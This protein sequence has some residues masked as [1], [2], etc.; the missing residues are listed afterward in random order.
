MKT[1]KNIL[2]ILLG[3]IVVAITLIVFI[4]LRN[5][6]GIGSGAT[7]TSQKKQTVAD[8]NVTIIT[9]AV[10]E[11]CVIN[12]NYLKL[13]N[14]EL[15]KDGHKYQLELKYFPYE[16]Y[17]QDVETE[18]KNGTVDVAFL[19]IGDDSNNIYSL[20]NSGSILNLDEILT[21]EKGKIVYDAFPNALWESVKC[22]KHIYSIPQTLAQETRVYAAFNTDYI[23]DEVIKNWDGSIDGIYKIIKDV[24]WDDDDAPRFQYLLSDFE[25]EQM[26][27]CEIK[28]GLLYDYETKQIIKPLE[29]EKLINYIKTLEQMKSDGFMNKSVSYAVDTTSDY[30]PKNVESG[31]F[32]I[33]LGVGEP[34]ALFES[35]N[36]SVKKL[37]PVLSS[38]ING[39]IGIS[40]KTDNIDEVIDFLGLLYG[41]SKYA[42]ILLYGRQD[43]DYKL[44]DG[45]AVNMDG[46]DIKSYFLTNLSLNLFINVHP[47][48]GEIFPENRK[49]EY[50]AYY[51]KIK[52]SPFI[53]FEADASGNETISVD[54]QNFLTSLNSC[55]LD[56]AVN[57]YSGRFKTDG[58]DEYYSSVKKQWESFNRSDI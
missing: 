22:N 39:S 4:N 50:F 58:I 33:I 44:V 25:F 41:E 57:N 23:S 21:T 10:P 1:R 32:L 49:E 56:D 48:K 29:S 15:Q 11:F 43:E 55:S 28:Y 54:L 19:G 37:A 40:N 47:V 45:L 16:T 27:G 18:L 51:N 38:R 34:Q 36:V 42:N 9:Y 2:L 8:K 6:P 30:K 26:I 12:N 14:E 20:I 53:G 13:F 5:K 24:K 17:C 31:K 7:T 35:D 52:L 3:I 46:T